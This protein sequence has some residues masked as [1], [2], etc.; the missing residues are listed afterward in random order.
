MSKK[1]AVKKNEASDR[2]NE[3]RNLAG[4]KEL[5]DK[6]DAKGRCW[7]PK[8]GGANPLGDSHIN[9]FFDDEMVVVVFDEKLGRPVIFE[10]QETWFY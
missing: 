4:I 1:K 7:G 5:W 8:R 3:I 9:L 10:Y 6:A 2:I